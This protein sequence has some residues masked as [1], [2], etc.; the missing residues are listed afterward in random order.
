MLNQ[1]D[2]EY[3]HNLAL[4]VC[5][6]CGLMQLLD[7]PPV[8]E[9]AP[10][11]SWITYNEPEAHLDQLADM[12]LGMV[13]SKSDTVIAGVSYKDDT[14]LERLRRRGIDW[15]WRIAPEELGVGGSRAEI[16]TVQK[17]LSVENSATI[18]K[19]HGCA[20]IVVVRHILEHAHDVKAFLGALKM[21]M[22]PEGIIVF[23][24]PDCKSVLSLK[25]YS[26]IWEE[27]VL[28]FTPATLS[29]CLESNGFEILQM[30]NYAYP[31]ENSLVV[32]ARLQ[33]ATHALP[34][35]EQDRLLEINRVLDYF[36]SFPLERAHYQ[37]ILEGY[38]KFGNKIVLFGAGH[39][40]CSYV[41]LMGLENYFEYILDDD[42]NR[43]GLF[44]PGSR[45][46][47]KSSA[48]LYDQGISLCLLS[49]NPSNENRVITKN[50]DFVERGGE[51]RSIFPTSD[52]ALRS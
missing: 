38:R 31:L 28:Y 6:A 41:N 49:L 5:L 35:T 19:R 17:R 48:A 2:P 13:A 45:L 7:P 30:E 34:L 8:E 15:V 52:L 44:M 39:L 4:G 12:L 36:D 33:K 3:N 1:T 14:T 37:Q 27:H 43:Q 23:E 29:V 50:R 51:F 32:L 18:G 21:L 40:A 25:D 46:Q 42:P 16:E 20:D 26:T 10:R 24:V 22:K 47:I 9:V 11:F